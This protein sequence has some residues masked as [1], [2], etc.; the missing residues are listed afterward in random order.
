MNFEIDVIGDDKVLEQLVA[1]QSDVRELLYNEVL[2]MG[3]D[4]RNDWIQLLSGYNGGPTSGTSRLAMVPNRLTGR[5]AIPNATERIDIQATDT[6]VIISSNDAK[7]LRIEYGHNGHDMKT[8]HPFGPKSRVSKKGEPYN[9]IPFRKGQDKTTKTPIPQPIQNVIEQEKKNWSFTKDTGERYFTPNSRG[10]MVERVR[11]SWGRRVDLNPT[12]FRDHTKKYTGLYRIGATVGGNTKTADYG[13]ISFRVIKARHN[14]SSWIIPAK[15][16]HHLAR[17]LLFAYM[18]RDESG[19]TILGK[20][21][22][23]IHERFSQ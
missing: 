11:H 5:H 9:I 8:T 14:A 3:I 7:V 21:R 15:E 22:E 20:I 17:N 6:G 12:P 10:E 4:F 2:K 13:I 18:K 16:G 23:S 19:D 1:W